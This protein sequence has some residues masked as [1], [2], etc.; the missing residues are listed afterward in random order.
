MLRRRATP[1]RISAAAAAKTIAR[2]RPVNGSSPRAR[3]R[4]SPATAGAAPDVGAVPLALA[5]STW[6]PGRV[7]VPGAA[8]APAAVVGAV[9]PGP[10]APAVGAVA[11]GPPAPAVGAGV[12]PEVDV[13]GARTVVAVGVLAGTVGGGVGK[14]GTVGA[15][16]GA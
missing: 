15:G 6:T 10:P 7:F 9:A 16:V 12:G 13:S 11:P 1:A 8:G 5:P 2:S 14:P 3:L 4:V